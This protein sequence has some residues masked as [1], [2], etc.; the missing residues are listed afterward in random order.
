MRPVQ[1][2]HGSVEVWP[3]WIGGGAVVQ[4][5]EHERQLVQLRG[6][7]AFTGVD[8]GQVARAG[9]VFQQ[10]HPGLGIAG[11][12]AGHVAGHPGIDATRS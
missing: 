2:A 9:Q 5:A 4:C 10:Q 1:L 8:P 3:W 6:L 12:Q 7:H 11:E